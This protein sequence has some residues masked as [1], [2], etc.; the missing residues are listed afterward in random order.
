MTFVQDLCHLV[1][2]NDTIM[3]LRGLF[4]YGKLKIKI[5]IGK[6]RALASLLATSESLKSMLAIISFQS[7]VG[8]GLIPNKHYSE[9][10]DGILYQPTP[11]V[12]KK[13]TFVR[14]KF[15]SCTFDLLFFGVHLSYR[16]IHYLTQKLSLLVI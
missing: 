9:L 8:I 14:S 15:E 7:P 1:T 13:C 2:A 10:S 12:K 11:Q 6:F 3:Q 16:L 5:F 4:F